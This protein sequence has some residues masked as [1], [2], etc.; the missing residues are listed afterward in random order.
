MPVAFIP[1]LL[2]PLGCLVIGAVVCS[3]FATDQG[4]LAGG[5]AGFV[6]GILVARYRASRNPPMSVTVRSVMVNTSP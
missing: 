6:A 3:L 1:S 4:Q 2:V 5:L